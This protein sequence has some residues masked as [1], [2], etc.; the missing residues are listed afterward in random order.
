MMLVL[1]CGGAIT[2]ILINSRKMSDY[3]RRFDASEVFANGSITA[4]ARTALE[5]CR[6]VREPQPYADEI[7][8]FFE[9]IAASE[10]Y[11]ENAAEFY[12]IRRFV[13]T[14]SLA[15]PNR[16]DFLEKQSLVTQLKQDVAIELFGDYWS[17]VDILELEEGTDYRVT[18]VNYWASYEYQ[19]P[20]TMT[21]FWLTK[22]SGSWKIYNDHDYGVN[23]S[24]A[25][26]YGTTMNEPDRFLQSYSNMSLEISRIGNDETLEPGEQ[27]E[28]VF[29]RFMQFQ[30][31]AC[32]RS[33][34]IDFAASFV[35]LTGEMNT[36]EKIIERFP[37]AN[38]P[39][40]PVYRAMVAQSR[41]ERQEVFD[42]L[43]ELETTFGWHPALGY[44][45]ANSAQTDAEIEKAC[46]WLTQGILVCPSH[47]DQVRAFYEIAERSQS[48]VLWEQVSKLPN[49]REVCREILQNGQL[50]NNEANQV[51]VDGIKSIP[52]FGDQARGVECKLAGAL[53]DYERVVEL[54]VPIVENVSRA[55][56]IESI[57]PILATAAV[58]LDR[59]DWVR[60][61]LA[62]KRLWTEAI[63][64][65]VLRQVFG[66]TD[67]VTSLLTY[68]DENIEESEGGREDFRSQL[69]LAICEHAMGE[70]GNVLGRL[71]PIARPV[72]RIATDD[73]ES[74]QASYAY[75][76]LDL[77]SSVSTRENESTVSIVDVCESIGI[78]ELAIVAMGRQ[79]DQT[80]ETRVGQAIDWYARQ[81]K[82]FAVWTEYYRA[83]LAVNAGEYVLAC[84]K[85]QAAGGLVS[86]QPRFQ[87]LDFSNLV[88]QFCPFEDDIASEITNEQVR[89]IRQSGEW[90]ALLATAVQEPQSDPNMVPR[91]AAAIANEFSAS[92]A[93][94]EMRYVSERLRATEMRA[95]EI[96]ADVLDANVQLNCQQYAAAAALLEDALRES[97]EASLE[98]GFSYV[99]A[100]GLVRCQLLTEL[101][102]SESAAA[103]V[104]RYFAADLQQ[105]TKLFDG[106]IKAKDL[107]EDF[108]LQ[109]YCHQFPVRSALVEKEL[110]ADVCERFP[111]SPWIFRSGGY[112]LL[113]THATAA[114]IEAS[115]YKSLQK[116]AVYEELKVRGAT[117]DSGNANWIEEPILDFEPDETVGTVETLDPSTFPNSTAVFRI[118]L[119]SN[120][121]PAD[122]SGWIVIAVLDQPESLFD[123]SQET[124]VGGR[125]A[126]S[127]IAI[128]TVNDVIV[129]D[130][131]QIVRQYAAVLAA[132]VS[133]TMEYRDG[134]TYS[135]F[136]ENEPDAPFGLA[137]QIDDAKL[138]G[139][140]R[141]DGRVYF[142]YRDPLS[143]GVAGQPTSLVIERGYVVETIPASSRMNAENE[144]LQRLNQTSQLVPWLTP[145]LDF[146]SL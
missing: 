122:D 116:M 104:G 83:Q 41:G 145:D 2:M 72:L 129:D 85:L 53:E 21:A 32:N 42:A 95:F 70:T 1:V 44:F 68:L 100:D 125:S 31:P 39:N 94:T 14:I 117:A 87:S 8:S 40:R 111:I 77:L 135:R 115:V 60:S 6:N 50:Y 84:Q 118:R 65:H 28:R 82:S 76:F 120:I 34:A 79:L 81:P 109:Y 36:L 105:L 16:Y 126:K 132:G 119:H 30:D 74:E 24:N 99:I 61:Q 3:K 142:L 108:N 17:I 33:L 86:V 57:M 80:N 127:A 106:E 69:A 141:N 71:M 101:R 55:E 59:L 98:E 11:W 128:S 131:F 66:D 146:Y 103:V 54:A 75:R 62:D 51:L 38:Y 15:S 29:Q 102:M 110:Y 9:T 96:A 19:F 138:T 144:E 137:S 124:S 43:Q 121:R 88:Y 114:E 136:I 48:A 25:G 18:I 27:A 52:E 63:R 92:E 90:S 91:L 47:G 4:S 139:S 107:P 73:G 23:Y 5:D 93:T 13:E 58:Q 45:A 78:P 64:T 26:Y 130:A 143:E 7:Q 35:S 123:F 56:E 140:P 10:G 12:D 113:L 22:E 134:R 97:S 46:R 133:S 20:P 89:V 112:G 67:D 49:A 37:E